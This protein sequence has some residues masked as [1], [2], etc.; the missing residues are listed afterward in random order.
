VRTEGRFNSNNVDLNRNFDCEWSSEATWQNR[1]VS[2]GNAPFSEPEA[3]A[4]QEYVDMYNP[5]A[6]VVWFSAEGKVYPSACGD[7]PSNASVTL[8][9]TYANSADYPV[10]AEFDAYAITGDM[11]NW[12]AKEGV[13]AISVLLSNHQDTE[14]SKNRAGIEAVINAYA[15]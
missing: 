13:P 2:G 15:N 6:A 1:Q 12:M 3:V 11:V 10:E 7:T 8:A 9:A 4:I 14:W 5:A